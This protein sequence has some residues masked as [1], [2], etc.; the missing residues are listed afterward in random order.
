MDSDTGRTT[1]RLTVSAHPWESGVLVRPDGELD[2][3]TAEPLERA[4]HA[5]RTAG[6]GGRTVVDC[7]G[8]LFCDS[9]G[10]NLLLNARSAAREGGGD[11][12]LARPVPMVARMLEVTGTQEVFEVYGTLD[13]ALAGPGGR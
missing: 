5:A 10:L 2:H 7:E 3:E 6:P 13:E 1:G 8:L 11:L 9:T 4:L 12:V